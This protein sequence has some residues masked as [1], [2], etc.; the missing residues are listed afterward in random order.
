VAA[1]PSCGDADTAVVAIGRFAR[2]GVSAITY[3][4]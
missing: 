4:G 1:F 3:D 2:A